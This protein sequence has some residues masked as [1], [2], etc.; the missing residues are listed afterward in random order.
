MSLLPARQNNLHY[1]PPTSLGWHL[2]MVQC[3]YPMPSS[4]LAS[5]LIFSGVQ[6][7]S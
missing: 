5:S 3:I 2:P 7:G 4:H 6:G 1:M